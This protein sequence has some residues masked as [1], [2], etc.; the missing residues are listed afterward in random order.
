MEQYELNWKNYNEILQVSPEAE[1]LVIAAAYKRLAQA[2]HPDMTK[3]PLAGARIPD[4]N[5]AYEVLSDPIRRAAYDRIFRT[6]YGQQVSDAEELPNEVIASLL[7]FA[8]ERAARGK[9]KSQI[10]DELTRQRVSHDMAAKVIET[11][12]E[13][14]SEFK[15]RR[16]EAIRLIKYGVILIVGGIVTRIIYLL[17]ASAGL[18]PI[19]IYTG[20]LIGG[21]ITL[22]IG[23]YKRATS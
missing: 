15:R 8:D 12:F 23:I 9:N 13:Y 6:K 20:L 22:V 19:V 11:V 14:R 21:V 2:Y 7:T 17:V 18:T 10:A 16:K 3:D 5:E 4:I 1:P